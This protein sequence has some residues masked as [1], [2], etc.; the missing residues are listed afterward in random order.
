MQTTDRLPHLGPYTFTT[1]S[2]DEP[3]D[4]LYLGVGQPGEALT[5]ESPEGHFVRLDP[6]T[7]EVVGLTVLCFA[8]R[9]ARGPI[10]VTVPA[11][12][13]LRALVESRHTEELEVPDGL[14]TAS[15]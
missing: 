6:D 4:V 8:G 3:G 5:W 12:A 13:E 10:A 14:L 9:K 2:Y 7:L 1:T 15:R 11:P